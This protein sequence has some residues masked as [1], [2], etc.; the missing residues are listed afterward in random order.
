MTYGNFLIACFH[1]HPV[2]N[3]AYNYHSPH[4]ALI[5]SIRK[6]TKSFAL[7]SP[8]NPPQTSF[9]TIF[10]SEVQNDLSPFA[11]NF[12]NGNGLFD[13]IKNWLIEPAYAADASVKPPT[14]VEIKLLREAFDAFYGQRNP[15]KAEELLTKTISAWERQPPDER[16]ALYRVRGDCYMGLM[17]ADEAVK[18]YNVAIELLEGPGGEKADPSE[19]PEARLGRARAIRSLDVKTKEQYAQA[20]EDYQISLRLSSRE[21]WDTDEENEQDGA[22]R[23][24]YAAWEWGMAQ[25]GKGDL[26]GAAETHTVASL[27]FKEIGDRAHS[28]ISALDAGIDLAATDDSA[29][30]KAVLED[31]IK[32]TTSVEGNDISLLQRVI[33]KE[34]EARIALASVLWGS[35]DK[36]GAEAQLGEACTRLDQLE[37]DFDARQAALKKS[38]AVPL[39][40]AEKLPFTIDDTVGAGR[41]SCSRF[42]NDK[43]LDDTLI[44]PESLQEK[45]KK[46]N[47][48]AN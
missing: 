38:G 16:A 25:R 10:P 23:N 3:I 43:F 28:V 37:A 31:A 33:A 12:R 19:R 15:A 40:K 9:Q 14:D 13:G 22:S 45:V 29:A 5:S 11:S 44:W 1:A 8:I 32:R 17:R 6:P 48:L 42:K 24:P 26:K 20:A 34:G 47:K 27:A 35:N 39:P 4:E 2:S 30:A 21:D 7:L 18:D 41:I 36:A 46:L